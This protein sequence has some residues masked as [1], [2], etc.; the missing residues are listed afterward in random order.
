MDSAAGAEA[1]A[2]GAVAAHRF[3][4]AA[5]TAIAGALAAARVAQGIR[6]EA[7]EAAEFLIGAQM[8]G[9]SRGLELRGQASGGLR[10]GDGVKFRDRRPGC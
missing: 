2:A 4:Q 3:P 9:R 10:S 7:Q 5:N 1:L 6:G 8:R